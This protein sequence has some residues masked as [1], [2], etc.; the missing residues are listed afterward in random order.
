MKLEV[1]PDGK[2]TKV[3]PAEVKLE[4]RETV[5]CIMQGMHSLKLPKN[6]GPLVS[7]LLPLELTTGSPAPPAPSP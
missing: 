4:D 5:S 2:V 7:I 3:A 1:D 6:P